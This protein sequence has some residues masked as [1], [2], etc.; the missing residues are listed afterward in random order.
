VTQIRHLGTQAC[1]L[2]Y[3]KVISIRYMKTL[4]E[5]R[6]GDRTFSALPSVH[7]R[8]KPMAMSPKN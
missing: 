2:A 8:A 7:P 1:N 4:A 5:E 3:I 6:T